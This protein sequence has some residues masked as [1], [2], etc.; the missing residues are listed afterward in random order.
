MKRPRGVRKVR[1]ANKITRFV[2]ADQ[3][4]D[5]GKDSDVGDGVGVARDPGVIC[6]SL[7]EHAEQ[8]SRFRHIAVARAFI[9]VV[10]TGELVE[11]QQMKMKF[12]WRPGYDE[13]Y[14]SAYREEQD[15]IERGESIADF[16]ARKEQEDELL[17]Y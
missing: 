13:G 15:R 2:K 7:I 16:T 1:D 11:E 14:R 3:V 5:P 4:A 9:F 6:Q 12:P 10:L 8:A 17:S